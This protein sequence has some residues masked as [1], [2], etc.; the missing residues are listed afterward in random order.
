[1]KRRNII[2]LILCTAAVLA[3]ASCSAASAANDTPDDLI[4]G[5]PS[6]RGPTEHSSLAEAEA[7]AGIDMQIPEKILDT[8]A[9]MFLTWYNE[10]CIEAIYANGGEEVARVR[11][12]EG[13]ADISGDYNDYSSVVDREINGVSVTFKGNDG[14]VMLAVWAVDGCGYSISVPNGITADEMAALVGQVK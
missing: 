2:A 5:D 10:K 14:K 12:D 4:G 8:K 13:S 11:K 9:S 3:L 1:M 7:A 6:T